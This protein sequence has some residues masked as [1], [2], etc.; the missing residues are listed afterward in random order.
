VTEK[1]A[2]YANLGWWLEVVA[3]AMERAREFL[4][5]VE[6]ALAQECYN[7]CASNA[8]Y[9]MFWAAIAA[10][11]HQGFKQTE[12]SHG[13][14]RE[15]FSRELVVKRRIYP[16]KFGEWLKDAYDLRVKADYKL[17]GVSAKAA[18]RI[19]HHAQEF[20]RAIQEVMLR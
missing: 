11:V 19:F 16:A 4:K 20:V 9:A 8:Y 12:W 15:I 17:E 6:I 13:G 5:V 3:V 2:G 18:R 14:L 10:L 1:F 7:A